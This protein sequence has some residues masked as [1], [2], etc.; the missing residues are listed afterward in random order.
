MS[1]DYFLLRFNCQLKKLTV[2]CFKAFVLA[3]LV[4]GFCT[5]CGSPGSSGGGVSVPTLPEGQTIDLSDP[6]ITAANIVASMKFGWNLGNTLDANYE[7]TDWNHQAG[8]SEI[9]WGHNNS[10]S[11]ALF[12]KLYN[13]GIRCVRIPISWHNHVTKV[14]DTWVINSGWMNHVQSV[15]NLAYGKG[16][17]VIINIHHDNFNGD[18][19]G[20]NPGFTL[21]NSDL[22]K[23]EKYVKEI[24]QQIAETFID[25]DGHLIFETLNEPRIIGGEHEWN[26]PSG[27]WTCS[28][29]QTYFGIINTLNQ[30]ALDT[31]RATGGNNA[32]RV[33]MFPAYVA[34]PYAAIN[35]KN[36]GIFTIP[37]DNASDK[38]ALS[39]HMYTPYN[40][41][42]EYP[43]SAT[44]TDS[45]KS[46]LASH[47][48]ALNTTFIS[49]GIPVV[50]GEMGATNKDNFDARKSWFTY[51]LGLC[52]HYNVAA[53]LWDNGMETNSENGSEAYG[54]MNRKASGGPAWFTE[55]RAGEL[56]EAAVNARN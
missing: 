22:E 8:S 30:D 47:F 43:G 53:V 11:E 31:I 25:Y 4:A 45:H 18:N 10:A 48:T 3:L 55:S 37:S 35:G 54:Y 29:C 26:C 39:V 34:A 33:V 28:E 21:I 24:W 36:A 14:N 51:Y 19:L 12:Q 13:D 32:N 49:Q 52:K 56:I 6:S 41:A 44:F 23:S 20:N 40:F 7:N 5:G 38:L 1:K 50:I 42:M 27:T 9:D 46:D 2:T 16:L 15:V 17:F